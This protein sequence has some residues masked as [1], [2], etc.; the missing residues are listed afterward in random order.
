MNESCPP[1]E[2][3]GTVVY[4]AEYRLM[5]SYGEEGNG[6]RGETEPKE[7]RKEGRTDDDGRK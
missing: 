5:F 1:K 7:A 4:T 3:A 2:R 6:G